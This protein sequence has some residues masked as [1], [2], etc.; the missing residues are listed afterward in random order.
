MTQVLDD[1][2]WRHVLQRKLQAPRQDGD[3]QLL[4]I[5]RR[6][7]KLYMLRRLLQRLQQGV[8]TVAGQHVHFVNQVDLEA[9]ARRR[10]LH[11]VQQFAGIFYLGAAGRID[12]N[13]VNETPLVNLTAGGAL[14]ARLGTYPPLTVQAFGKNTRDRGFTHTAGAGKQIGVVQPVVIQRVDQR[15]QH[16]RLPNHFTE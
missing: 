6:Q 5:G 14:P 12:L 8:E 2:L 3:R 9:A 15:L 11:V 4:W 1:L 13:Q 10:V 16:M 7:Q